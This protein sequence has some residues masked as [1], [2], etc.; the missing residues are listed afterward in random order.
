MT[1]SYSSWNSILGGHV[2]RPD[3]LDAITVNYNGVTVHVYGVVHGITGGAN[4]AYIRLV[5]RTIRQAEGPR[6]CEKSMKMI[7][8]GLDQDVYDWLQIPFKD[9]FGFGLSLT[10]YPRA[11]WLIIRTMLREKSKTSQFGDNNVRILGDLGGDALFHMLDPQQRRLLAGLPSSEDYLR[12]NLLRRKNKDKRSLVFADHNWEWLSY[13]E[14]YANIP[15]RSVHMIEYAVAW[16]RREKQ[17]VVS[18]FVGEGHNTDI[19]W[20]VNCR[21]SNSLP[22]EFRDETDKAIKIAQ[23]AVEGSVLGA[24]LKYL[25]GATLAASTSALVYCLIAQVL[26]FMG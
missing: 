16:A 21:N 8:E 24:Q 19:Q 11:L 1:R 15:M 17:S 4:Q 26:F 22:D 7:Y 12:L 18:L 23:R 13:A 6:L 5:N 2:E 3:T 10:L 9:S 20:Y 25:S 14:K